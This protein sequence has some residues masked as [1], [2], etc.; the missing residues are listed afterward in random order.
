MAKEMEMTQLVAA[1]SVFVF[2]SKLRAWLEQNDPKALQQ[3]RQALKLTYGESHP[4]P[5]KPYVRV[6][7][8]GFRSAPE[9]MRV[10]EA[11]RQNSSGTFDYVWE[12]L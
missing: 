1:L 6:Y 4:E 8:D 12:A 3:A 10:S 5:Y 9:P 7:P 11:A 2:D